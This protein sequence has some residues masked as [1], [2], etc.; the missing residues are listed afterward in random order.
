MYFSL[1]GRK[2]Y[3]TP[4]A[5][6]ELLGTFAKLLGKKKQ[7]LLKLRAR[8]ANGLEKLLSTA[9]EVAFLQEERIAVIEAAKV[10][11][12]MASKDLQSD[13]LGELPELGTILGA[14]QVSETP[15]N[16]DLLHFFLNFGQQALLLLPVS[17]VIRQSGPIRGDRGADV[18]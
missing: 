1:L 10:L 4:T 8:T 17:L 15:P 11:I 12:G 7:E 18:I 5:Y 14:D 9:K 2:N 6:L 16:H 3:V 13:R